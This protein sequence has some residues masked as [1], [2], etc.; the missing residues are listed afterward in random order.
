MEIEECH[1]LYSMRCLGGG[2]IQNYDCSSMG[3]L[4]IEHNPL[5]HMV[6]TLDFALEWSLFFDAHCPNCR[7]L[8]C[9]SRLANAFVNS[10]IGSI[11][12]ET[13]TSLCSLSSMFAV[14]SSSGSKG[15]SSP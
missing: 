13:C 2:S 5:M 6:V 4:H 7:I 14:L 15:T 8:S 10:M 1:S 3:Y 11:V 9:F 12:I